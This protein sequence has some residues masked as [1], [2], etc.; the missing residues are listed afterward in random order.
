MGI[1]THRAFI[2]AALCM[3]GCYGMKNKRP[4]VQN[5]IE[6]PVSGAYYITKASRSLSMPAMVVVPGESEFLEAYE[7]TKGRN[8]IWE[9]NRFELIFKDFK[10]PSGSF[11]I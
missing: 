11:S 4:T 2:L 6:P 5:G 7:K 9:H 3:T 8:D 1:M 10:K